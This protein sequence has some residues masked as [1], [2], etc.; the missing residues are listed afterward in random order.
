MC[1]TDA[2]IE[3]DAVTTS[4]TTSVTTPVTTP[5]TTSVTTD[6]GI[7]MD[8]EGYVTKKFK[9]AYSD[10]ILVA[11][12]GEVTARTATIASRYESKP[13]CVGAGT[14]ALC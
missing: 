2:G 12:L 1:R 11:A 14:R 7:E 13:E 6:A 10:S 3:M 4:V 8:E 9:A 5:V